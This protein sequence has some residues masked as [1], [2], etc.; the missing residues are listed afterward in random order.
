MTKTY[1][2]WAANVPNQMQHFKSPCN[3][4]SVILN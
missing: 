3:C 1:Q 2:E 4:A